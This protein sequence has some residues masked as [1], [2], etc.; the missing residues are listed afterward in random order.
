[1]GPFEFED[2]CLTPQLKSSCR[3]WPPHDIEV[4]NTINLWFCIRWRS[5]LQAI[6]HKVVCCALNAVSGFHIGFP[7]RFKLD[8]ILWYSN[9]K[10][11]EFSIYHDNSSDNNILG[12]YPIPPPD[13]NYLANIFG[14]VFMED[15]ANMMPV[16]SPR[17]PRTPHTGNQG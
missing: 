12:C 14:P 8:F 13:P 9:D 10:G 6:V 2:Q 15:P 1:M 16:P 4:K 3:L 11:S 5:M 7:F 17:T